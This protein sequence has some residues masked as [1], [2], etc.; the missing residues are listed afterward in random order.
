LNLSA[1]NARCFIFAAVALFASVTGP[2]K[3]EAWQEERDKSTESAGPVELFD[4]KT[5]D[6]WS[7]DPRYWS[8]ADGAIVGQTTS[9]QPLE[10]N[11]FLIWQGGEVGDFELELEFRISSV[12]SGLQFRSV[13][14]DDWRVTGYQADMDAANDHTGSIYEE[15]G[16]GVLVPRARHVIIDAGGERTESDEATCDEKALRESLKKGGWNRLRVVARGSQI[17]YSVNDFI[18][19]RLE[20]G[21]EGKSRGSG[22]IALQLH[23]GDPMRAEF[24]NIRLRRED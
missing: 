10:H 11:T 19:A 5:L 23:V 18:T 3:A 9:D 20:D 14:G 24:R 16:R 1:A 15:G 8:V 12:N 2:G 7:G 22:V 4:G 6:G 17:T 21:E 13:A